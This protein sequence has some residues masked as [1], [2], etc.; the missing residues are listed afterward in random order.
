RRGGVLRAIDD[1]S[2]IRRTTHPIRERIMKILK[3]YALIGGLF[4]ALAALAG[5]WSDVDSD[6]P[7]SDGSTGSIGL[8]L[9]LA[10]GVTVSTV[11]WTVSNAGTGFSKTG[12]VNVETSNRLE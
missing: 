4:G 2:A 10:P 1:A 6:E 7:I 11:S 5:C 8:E 3:R 9:E 12:S